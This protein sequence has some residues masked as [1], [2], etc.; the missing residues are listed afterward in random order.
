MTTS[1]EELIDEE[2]IEYDEELGEEEEEL[3]SEEISEIDDTDLMKR[4]EAKYG[5]I[6]GENSDEDEDPDGSWTSNYQHMNR[7]TLSI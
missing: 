6:S 3:E 7:L 4:L 1:D 2:E 5:K